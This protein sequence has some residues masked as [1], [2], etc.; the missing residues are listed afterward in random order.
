MV[1]IWQTTIPTLSGDTPRS[2]YVYL[3]TGYSEGHTRYPVLYLLDGQEAFLQQDAR[4][5][6]CF[7]LDTLLDANQV[8]LIVVAVA[9][10]ADVGGAR[11][12]E[13]SPFDFCH[14]VFGDHIGKG[15]QTM[16]WYVQTLKPQIDSQYRTLPDRAHTYIMGCSMGGLMSLY[17]VLAYND[18]FHGAAALS[19]SLWVA[20][21]PM[22]TLIR[23]AHIA[24]DTILYMDCGQIEMKQ[25]RSL[26]QLFPDFSKALE[27]RGVLLTQRIIPGGQ[28]RSESWKR[29][30]PF[31]LFALLYTELLS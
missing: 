26:E 30:L 13:Y 27:N 18:V 16:D 2:V 1:E 3:P 7:H 19:P 29:Q 14:K 12:D 8:P 15:K 25:Q 9:C 11:L 4:F 23:T 21:G 24:P 20:P 28:H 22:R 5:G 6:S 17:A 31:V 10:N